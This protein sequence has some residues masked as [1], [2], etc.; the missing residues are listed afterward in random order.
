MGFSKATAGTVVVVDGSKHLYDEV[1]GVDEKLVSFCPLF[2]TS[3][4]IL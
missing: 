2:F 3:H 1:V 4:F